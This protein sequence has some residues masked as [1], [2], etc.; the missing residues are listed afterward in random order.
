M[1]R[2]GFSTSIVAAMSYSILVLACAC[3]DA[4]VAGPL[5]VKN[6][7]SLSARQTIPSHDADDILCSFMQTHKLSLPVASPASEQRHQI[8]RIS[9]VIGVEAQQLTPIV[10]AYRP[11]GDRSGSANIL[12]FQ[13]STVL[14]I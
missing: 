9:Q 7:L 4:K 2:V 5:G 11:P 13:L 6:V 1:K 12:G 8:S 10:S 14:R 3:M